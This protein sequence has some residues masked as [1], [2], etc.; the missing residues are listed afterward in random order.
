MF[1]RPQIYN[2]GP[3][4]APH[5]EVFID[6]PYQVGND[7]PL[8]KWLLYLEEI[9]FIE[10]AGGGVCSLVDSSNSINPLGLTRKPLDSVGMLSA[11]LMDEPALLRRSN[12]SYNFAINQ[13]SSS[14]EEKH[15]SES[16]VLNRV[17]R[18]RAM[19]IRAD[20]L[21]DSDGKKTNIV[22][23]VINSIQVEKYYNIYQIILRINI[24]R[25]AE[26]EL[27]NVLKLSVKF[28]IFNE[29]LKHL[30]I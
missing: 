18:D 10:G 25:I 7:K 4:K 26:K 11:P 2:S 29:K 12:K 13:K 14:Y 24:Y 21:V 27:P 19:I 8:G 3:W 30:F 15:S 1:F 9:P 20:K 22:T 6:W 5:V 17:K 23:M 28:S 16:T